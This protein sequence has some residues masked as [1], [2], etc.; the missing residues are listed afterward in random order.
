VSKSK[1]ETE[2]T[3]SAVSPDNEQPVSD[4][5]LS[6]LL[7]A[8]FLGICLVAWYLV[9]RSTLRGAPDAPVGVMTARHQ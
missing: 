6:W 4:G 3:S 5:W 8:L 7:L 9:H 1:K 2:Q